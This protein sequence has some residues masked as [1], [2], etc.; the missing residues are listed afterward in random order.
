MEF[1]KTY[2]ATGAE[3][4]TDTVSGNAFLIFSSCDSNLTTII[5]CG[6]SVFPLVCYSV[7]K[8]QN[9]QARVILM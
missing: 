8:L 3:T 7:T 1:Y 2:H 9:C 4:D 6:Y 5:V